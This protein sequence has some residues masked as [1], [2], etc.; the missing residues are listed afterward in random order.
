M[1]FPSKIF[2]AIAGIAFGLLALG[3]VAGP[4]SPAPTAVVAD[5]PWGRPQ[6]PNPALVPAFVTSDDNPWG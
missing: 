2:T 6:P 1:S 5:N 3:A 4:A